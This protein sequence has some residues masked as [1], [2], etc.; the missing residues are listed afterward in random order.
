MDP[1]NIRREGA[2]TMQE[3]I[4]GYLEAV[5]IGRH[6]THKN[7]TLFPLLSTYALDLDY[8]LLEEALAAGVVEVVEVSK[9]GS[10]PD[11]K[12]VNNSPGM[13][14]ILDGEELVGA[15]QNRIVN[16][17]ILIAGNTT[18]V[19]PVS[20]VESGRWAYDSPK[21]A[22]GSRIMASQ[23]RGMKAQQVHESLRAS[24]SYRSNQGAIWDEIAD[25]A[26]RRGAESPSMAMNVIY[27]KDRGSTE[28][29]LSHFSPIQGQV[30][31]VFMINGQVVGMDCF[32]KAESFS[33]VFRKLVESYALDAIDWLEPDKEV[34]AHKSEVTEFLKAGL[35]AEVESQPSVGT[36]IDC[37][38]SSRKIT[39]FA[40]CLDGK[41]LHLSIF[42]RQ[43]G[44][45]QEISQ[46]RMARFSRRSGYRP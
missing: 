5:K 18:V 29:Y 7:L 41:L 45:G 36:G 9:E 38:L 34:K 8:V 32:G 17:T 19:I 27:E 39:G 6:Q 44:N 25:K 28:E 24:R 15:K 14:L 4:K 35:A 37:R 12:V 13:V 42:A 40:L 33:K 30:G 31:A 43:N 3:I 10:V 2:K 11:L 21:F 20:C 23:M 46:S 1:E 26:R 16:T 22:A